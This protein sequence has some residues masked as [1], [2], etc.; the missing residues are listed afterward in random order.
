MSNDR[1]GPPRFT[2][3]IDL[4]RF[5]RGLIEYL[6]NQANRSARVR[7]QDMM[8][9]PEFD[10]ASYLT[11]IKMEPAFKRDD[12]VMLFDSEVARP[13]P[14]RVSA[15]QIHAELYAEAD[16]ALLEPEAF[17]EAAPIASERAVTLMEMGFTEQAEVMDLNRQQESYEK[18]KA[19]A[20]RDQKLHN[21]VMQLVVRFPNYK[22]LNQGGLK[23][24]TEKYGL[25]V[26][27]VD[28]FIGDI[29]D[30]N[31]QEMAGF[32]K[33][34]G[35]TKLASYHMQYVPGRYYIAAPPE[36][37]KQKNTISSFQ[38]WLLDDPIVLYPALNGFLI[39]TAWGDEAKDAEVLNERNN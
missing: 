18:R 2:G 8:Y 27:S 33:Q 7:F 6:V 10:A 32:V 37:F 34:L 13:K 19:I 1:F 12:R 17:T 24:V 3:R 5:D 11:Q 23:K 36:Q 21:E 16:V 26:S 22:F 15:A 20:D 14:K 29:P 4:T 39:V 30:K 9:A 25:Q 31:V 28:N 38:Q 35:D